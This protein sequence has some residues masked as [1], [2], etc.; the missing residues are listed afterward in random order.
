MAISAHPVFLYQLKFPLKQMVDNRAHC[1]AFRAVID[2]DS[3]L[4]K[5]HERPHADASHYQDIRTAL[6]QEVHRGL[7]STMLMRRIVHHRD[8]A[9]FSVFNMY[10]R[11]N[12]AM[13]EVA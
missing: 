10:Q 5:A 12:I 11:K 13:P 9:D 3:R 4:A 1:F 2:I 8:I 7:A 6:L